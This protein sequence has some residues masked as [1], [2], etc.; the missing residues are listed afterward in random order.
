MP[1]SSIVSEPPRYAGVVVG[2]IS[3]Y[4]LSK[5]VVGNHVSSLNIMKAGK[6]FDYKVIFLEPNIGSLLVN[7]SRALW[8]AKLPRYSPCCWFSL[9]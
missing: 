2:V 3:A 5:T 9:G 1:C 7:S 4:R 8:G 6:R